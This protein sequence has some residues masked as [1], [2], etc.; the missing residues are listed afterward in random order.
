[1]SNKFDKMTG[2]SLGFDVHDDAGNVVASYRLRCMNCGKVD[3][4]FVPTLDQRQFC[5]I[6]CTCIVADLEA[7][8][9]ADMSKVGWKL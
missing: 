5:C 4:K 9:Q 8:I 1:M 7:P 2:T 3:G 6:V